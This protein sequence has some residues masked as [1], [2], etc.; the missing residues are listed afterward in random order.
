MHNLKKNLIFG[1]LISNL[2]KILLFLATQYLL[3]PVAS[4]P[5]SSTLKIKTPPTKLIKLQSTRIGI[6]TL[7]PF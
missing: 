3:K 1:V 2:V 4:K 7:S 5:L 6:E